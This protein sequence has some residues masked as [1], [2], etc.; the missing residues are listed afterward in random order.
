MIET[1]IAHRG[2]IVCFCLL[3]IYCLPVQISELAT[4]AGVINR[5]TGTIL[6]HFHSRYTAEYAVDIW[7]LSRVVYI[8]IY[9]YIYEINK[10]VVSYI[11]KP[12]A[13]K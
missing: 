10:M 3:T 4:A 1:N 7:F 12:Y 2:L 5:N 11:L 9:I 6:L 8:Y 13:T